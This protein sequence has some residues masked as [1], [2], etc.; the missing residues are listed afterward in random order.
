MKNTLLLLL[1][2]AFFI[3]RTTGQDVILIDADSNV[4][5]NDT[6]VVTGYPTDNLI[7]AYVYIKNE[8]ESDIQ[9]FVRKIE[10][11]IVP[12]AFASFCWNSYCFTPEVF[13]VD[14][15]L[16]LSAGS[17]SLTD[18]FYGEYRS[19]GNTGT[20]YITFEFYSRNKDFETIKVVVEYTIQTA[21]S[22]F[23]SEKGLTFS[24]PSPNP[25]G[26]YTSFNY[27]IPFG[28]NQA[29][30]VVRDLTGRIV[31]EEPVSVSENQLRLN[32]SGL[33]TGI[34]LYSLVLDGKP[35]ITR[36]LIVAR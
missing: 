28:T 21:S 13:E 24:P 27:S 18:D 17:T 22:A 6:L 12:G 25:A 10:D 31:L 5:T 16:E 29:S 32:L 19:Q 30:I 11:Y 1:L 7:K 34:F 4:I 14:N 2:T 23:N 35:V 3:P 36:K 9:V 15:P 8:K 20:S 26:S 33:N